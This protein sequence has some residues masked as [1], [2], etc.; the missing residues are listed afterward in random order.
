MPD[1]KEPQQSLALIPTTADEVVTVVKMLAK[2]ALVPEFFRNSKN[3]EADL[4]FT[5]SYGMDMGFSPTQSLRAINV[6]QGKPG[7]YADAMVALV[8][9]SGKAKY[10]RVAESTPEKV[11][12]ETCR[13]GQTKIARKTFTLNDAVRAGISK[14]SGWTKYP[15]HMLEARAKSWLARDCYPD[16]L[17]GVY[18]SEELQDLEPEAPRATDFQAIVEATVVSEEAVS[19]VPEYA[20]ASEVKDVKC[21]SVF[22]GEAPAPQV[23]DTRPA[24][25]P[26]ID[27]AL[28]F[29]DPPEGDPAKPTRLER[30]ESAPHMAALNAVGAEC[31]DITDKAERKEHDAAYR[32]RWHEL[33]EG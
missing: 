12:Y 3:P 23:S 27:D 8:M 6:I 18:S 17:H 21:E 9:G 26:D 32:K 33:K 4:Y 5:I 22:K 15:Q 13:T 11:T 25:E 30:L 10:F 2:S 29:N 19:V 7:L 14:G 20:I 28:G 24:K 16:V 31:A 1:K